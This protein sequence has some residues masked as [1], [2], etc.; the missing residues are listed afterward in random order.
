MQQKHNELLNEWMNECAFASCVRK[1]GG[2]P[3]LSSNVHNI[4]STI[5]IYIYVLYIYRMLRKKLAFNLLESSFPINLT[6]IEWKECK[7]S[8]HFHFSIKI[9]CQSKYESLITQKARRNEWMKMRRMEKRIS[10][11]HIIHTHIHRTYT[12]SGAHQMDCAIYWVVEW[13]FCSIAFASKSLCA[14]YRK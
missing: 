4:Y 6:S 2:L 11:N 13:S 7:M 3:L 12:Y 14:A 5:H 8:L 1:R 9:V 10:K